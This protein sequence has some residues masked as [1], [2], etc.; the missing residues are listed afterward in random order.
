MDALLPHQVR[1]DVDGYIPVSVI[2]E[3]LVA[4]GK[5]VAEAAFLLEALI[6]GLVIER[7]EVSV[8]RVVHES[9]LREVF[10]VAI[11]AAFQAGLQTD[12]PAIVTDLT[13][14][15]VPDRYHNLLTVIV[16]MIAVYGVSKTIERLFPTKKTDQIDESFKSLTLVAGD[17]IQMQP[18]QIE[19]AVRARLADKKQ[20]QLTSAI[21]SFFAPTAGH[22]GSTIAGAG[23]TI[24]ASAIAQIPDFNTAEVVAT[25][26]AT[27]SQMENGQ[28]I[29][30]HA[31]DRDRGKYGWAGHI[32]EFFDDRVPM[33]LDKKIN[34]ESLFTKTEIWGDVLI[35]FDIDSEGVRT[36][37]EFHL[38]RIV[39]PPK[40]K[41]KKIAPK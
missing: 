4:N 35:L 33:K 32:P 31:M 19:T 21:R 16:M 6:P 3:S 38:L 12:M 24:G 28:K 5:L 22:P 41:Q 36:P 17:L 40:P 2:A 23:T 15:V 7:A 34:P 10:A 29:I 39:N 1:Y 8:R 37:S 11:V 25:K 13:G 27:E 20:G 18:E 9:P 26:S 30:I 14:L